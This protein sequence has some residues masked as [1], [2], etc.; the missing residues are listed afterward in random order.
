RYGCVRLYSNLAELQRHYANRVEDAD[1]V[2]VGSY[3]PDGIEIGQWVTSIARGVTAFYDIAPAVTLADLEVDSCEYINRTILSKYDL[4]LSC[5]GG[6]ILQQV[7]RF[8]GS[9]MA[10]VLYCSIDPQAYFPEQQINRWDLGYI[11]TYCDDR[12]PLL[13]EL[14]LEPAQ[15]WERGRFVVAGLKY[16]EDLRWPEN[17]HRIQHLPPKA[18]RDFYNAQ[19]FMLS[20]TRADMVNSGYSPN[21]LLFEAAACATPIVT[22][23]WQ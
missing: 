19:K 9:R 1:C 10:R 16:P 5:T 12:Q 7:E 6:P 8:Y 22:D 11:G 17:V 2:I 15:Q 3:V 23:Y 4:Y 20:I 21:L 18:H 14:L 13:N